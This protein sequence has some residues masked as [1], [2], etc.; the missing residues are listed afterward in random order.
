MNR[1]TEQAINTV[2]K[3]N[4]YKRAA[5]NGIFDDIESVVAEAY[6][7]GVIDGAND[8]ILVKESKETIK[9]WYS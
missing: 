2:K 4:L 8:N 3:Y 9:S 5:D 7:R 6:L 1:I